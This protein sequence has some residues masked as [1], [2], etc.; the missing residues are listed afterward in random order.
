[1]EERISINRITVSTRF[2]IMIYVSNEAANKEGQESVQQS[3]TA[4]E[5]VARLAQRSAEPLKY[6]QY[7]APAHRR[8]VWAGQTRAARSGRA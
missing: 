6:G 2:Q 5:V 8:N 4:K 7:S 3:D 1:M